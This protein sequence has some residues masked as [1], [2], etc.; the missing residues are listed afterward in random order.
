MGVAGNDQFQLDGTQS[1]LKEELGAVIFGEFLSGGAEHQVALSSQEMQ[2]VMRMVS[3]VHGRFFQR[4][5]GQLCA[6]IPDAEAAV[7]LCRKLKEFVQELRSLSREHQNLSARFIAGYGSVVVNGDRLRSDWTFHL[8]ALLLKVPVGET[9]ILQDLRIEVYAS[10]PVLGHRIKLNARQGDVTLYI[11]DF[12]AN[13]K[14][15]ETYKSNV[16]T[17]IDAGVF[18]VLRLTIRGEPRLVRICDCPLPIGRHRSCAIVVRGAMNSRFHGKIEYA[19]G[20]FYYVDESRNGSYALTADGEEVSLHQERIAL[21]GKGAISPGAPIALQKG[22]VIRYDCRP[23]KL[24]LEQMGQAAA[25]EPMTDRL[26]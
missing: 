12:D 21:V 2:Q 18:A 23:A 26:G 24:S 5:G 4:P 13:D 3:R 16:D 14:G 22:D 7:E 11:V 15:G 8:P 9:A 20:K 6:F 19:N 1:N 10:Y 17:S 25:Q